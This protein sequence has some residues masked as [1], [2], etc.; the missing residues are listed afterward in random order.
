MQTHLRTGAR[1]GGD[2]P[3]SGA[4]CGA[5]TGLGPVWLRIGVRLPVLVPSTL[6]FIFALFARV[7]K[8]EQATATQWMSGKAQT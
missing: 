5:L 3:H 7:L 4:A 2:K 1:Y 6:F 8:I